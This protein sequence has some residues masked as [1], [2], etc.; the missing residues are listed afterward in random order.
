M[1]KALLSTVILVGL[2]GAARA[3]P[4]M[5]V[6]DTDFRQQAM[7]SDSFEIESSR[8]ALQN[9]RNPRIRAFASMMIRDHSMTTAALSSGGNRMGAGP[10][11]STVAGAGVGFLVGGPVGAAV[12]AGVG[13]TAAA[14]GAD[15][16]ARMP[17]VFV[18]QRRATMLNQL[19][20]A[21]GRQ[22][23]ALYASMQVRAHQEAVGL[24]SAYA[25][26]GRDPTLASFAAQTLPALQHHYAMAAR[27]R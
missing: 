25:Q 26:G 10:A 23:D 15:V 24:F 9:S 18:D 21:Q 19:A 5:P 22:F 1:H 6:S 27:L 8:L 4:V 12:G 7:M 11:G 2:A 14:A 16:P 20:A 17:A 13:T 3:Q